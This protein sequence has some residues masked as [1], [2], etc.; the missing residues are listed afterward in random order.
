MVDLNSLKV[1]ELK[2]ELTA[3]GLSPKGL[4]K[5]LVARLE[6]AMAAERSTAAPTESASE[7]DVAPKEEAPDHI[8]PKE[9]DPNRGGERA[10]ME[11][12]PSSE[13]HTTAS[14]AQE[15]AKVV[16]PV[17]EPIE[18]SAV[19]EVVMAD[20]P[21]PA[22][23]K[24][25][26][27][28][29]TTAAL[30]PVVGTPSL[31]LEGFIDTTTTSSSADRQPSESK[32]RPLEAMESSGQKGSTSEGASST[33][34]KPSKRIKAIEINR[35]QCEKTAAA[36]RESLEA[37]A[38]RRSIAQSTS[39]GVDRPGAITSTP[40]GAVKTEEEDSH[41]LSPTTSKSNDQDKKA[42][43][44][45][46]FDARSMIQ[47]QIKLAAKSLQ[48]EVRTKPT[49]SSPT[50]KTEPSVEEP[51]KDMTYAPVPSGTATRSLSITNFVRPLT[52]PQVKRMLLEFGEIEVLWMDSIKSHCYVTFKETASAEKAYS[53][54]KGQIFPKE[55]GKPLS[56]HFITP[57]AAARSI[58]AAEE[59]QRSGKRPV[60]YT[61]ESDR[62]PVV[63]PRRGTSISVQKEDVAVIF[64]RDTTIEQTQ[65][66]QPTELF[67]MT[68][69]QPGLYY[70]LA[71]E[72]NPEL[73]TTSAP[74]TTTTAAIA[75]PDEAVTTGTDST[76]TATTAV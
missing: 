46:R 42:E 37:D 62:P 28:E 21:E 60:I 35:E 44:E 11:T 23:V 33:E 10:D 52:V 45:R 70:K 71:K 9:E 59:A 1:P 74:T 41:P 36:A 47:K 72:F 73:S 22:V 54:V 40:A 32:K 27:S 64:K 17:A 56:P 53:Q 18:T 63:V 39:P 48:P 49:V 58:E 68:K 26:V 13:L 14:E 55:T 25:E 61:G 24:E 57:E 76:S 3:R 65:V 20:V 16:E 6:E 69:T 67:K 34:A 75:A 12:D 2:A 4:K 8:A 38:R 51:S 15:I 30:E 66:V 43:G 19:A 29:S 31:S 7:P 50:F 5:E